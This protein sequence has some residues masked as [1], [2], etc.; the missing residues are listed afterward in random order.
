M[1]TRLWKNVSRLLFN[2]GGD[3][4]FVLFYQ[5]S[6]VDKTKSHNVWLNINFCSF[7]F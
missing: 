5:K 3:G 7:E 2:I 4:F 6:I 1:L